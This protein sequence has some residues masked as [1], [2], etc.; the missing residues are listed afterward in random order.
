[1]PEPEQSGRGAPLSSPVGL[2]PCHHG[3]IFTL[4]RSSL[5]CQLLG[6]VLLALVLR[7]SYFLYNQ[8]VNADSPWTWQARAALHAEKR[9]MGDTDPT[10]RMSDDA[11]EFMF[12]YGANGQTY[13]HIAI[14]WVCGKSSLTHMQVLQM[15]VDALLTLPIMFIGWTIGGRRV[16]ILSGV[17]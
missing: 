2:L 6:V 17:A 7:G 12:V 11:A 3:R 1:L 9:F 14:A 5:R 4:L 10:P 15:F 8:W 16:G 13:L